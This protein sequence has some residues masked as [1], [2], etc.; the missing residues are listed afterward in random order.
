MDEARLHE[1]EAQI[2]HQQSLLAEREEAVRRQRE[3]IAALCQE[4]EL[5]RATLKAEAEKP[6]AREAQS[7]LPF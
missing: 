4:L 1:L 5:L 7:E 6:A 2:A 3:R